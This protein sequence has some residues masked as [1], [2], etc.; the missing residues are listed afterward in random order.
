MDAAHL[1][2]CMLTEK[3]K[4][5]INVPH[6]SAKQYFTDITRGTDVAATVQ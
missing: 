2:G 4:K 1:G 3:K 5:K 6:I